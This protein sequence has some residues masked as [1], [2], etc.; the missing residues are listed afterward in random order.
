MRLGQELKAGEGLPNASGTA[1]W[2]YLEVGYGLSK[3][4]EKVEGEG[5]GLLLL[6]LFF[7]G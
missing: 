6:F 4:K 1:G 5:E 2:G 3:A 7:F